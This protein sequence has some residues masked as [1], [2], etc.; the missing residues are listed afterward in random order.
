MRRNVVKFILLDRGEFFDFGLDGFRVRADFLDECGDDTADGRL[1]EI[2]S[3][4]ELKHG[5]S[6][7]SGDVSHFVEL[8]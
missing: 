3:A 1:T 4:G 5:E 8:G 6:V 2:P 7:M